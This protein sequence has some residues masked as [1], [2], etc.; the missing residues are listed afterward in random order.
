MIVENQSSKT[1]P[2]LWILWMSDIIE[3]YLELMKRIKHRFGIL[4]NRSLSGEQ[5]LC[6]N[7][8]TKRWWFTAILKATPS[9][10]CSNQK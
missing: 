9:M 10:K 1:L 8:V 6:D 3:T 2:T 4:N 7:L 5:E